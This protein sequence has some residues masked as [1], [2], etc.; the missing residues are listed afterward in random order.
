MVT[1]FLNKKL[2]MEQFLKD[3][4]RVLLCNKIKISLVYKTKSTN[5]I[6]E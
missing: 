2:K 1:F 6:M 5:I 4:I 3:W